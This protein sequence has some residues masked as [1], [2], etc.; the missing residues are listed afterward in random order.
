MQHI[1]FMKLT[2]WKYKSRPVHKNVQ[3][4]LWKKKNFYGYANFFTHFSNFYF[5]WV[6]PI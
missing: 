2:K 3:E 6:M 1:K 5:W 4:I